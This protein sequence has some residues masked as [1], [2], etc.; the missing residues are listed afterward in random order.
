MPSPYLSLQFLSPSNKQ[1]EQCVVEGSDDGTVAG[2]FEND[3]KT[4]VNDQ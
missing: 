4:R 3:P 1:E 2:Q